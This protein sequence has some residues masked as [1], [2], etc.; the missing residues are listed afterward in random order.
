[1]TMGGKQFY[2]KKLTILTRLPFTSAQK[3]KRF[4]QETVKN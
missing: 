4:S 1:M 2:A 3:G